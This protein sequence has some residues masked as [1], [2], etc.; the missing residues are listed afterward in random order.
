[1]NVD[2]ALETREGNIILGYGDMVRSGQILYFVVKFKERIHLMEVETSEIEQFPYGNWLEL[3]Q[4]VE[5]V[6]K[7]ANLIIMSKG[8][9]V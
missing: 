8:D 4:E 5:L 6:E 1:M 2:K 3:Q 7:A 9:I